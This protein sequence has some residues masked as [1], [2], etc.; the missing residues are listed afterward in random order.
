MYHLSLTLL[1]RTNVLPFLVIVML[2]TSCVSDLF[3]VAFFVPTL[4]PKFFDLLGFLSRERL[5]NVT[6][7]HPRII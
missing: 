5:N 3:I 6:G 2:G 4:V 7:K 1:N